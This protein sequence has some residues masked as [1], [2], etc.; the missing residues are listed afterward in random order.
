MALTPLQGW[1][2]PDAASAPAN[3]ASFA[4]LGSAA[5]KQSVMVFASAAARDAAI[6][7]A[8]RKKGMIAFLTDVAWWTGVKVDGGAWMPVAGVQSYR[9]DQVGS[10]ILTAAYTDVPSATVTLP[11]GQWQVRATGTIDVSTTGSRLYFMRVTDGVN[12]NFT[13][14]RPG[15]LNSTTYGGQYQFVA[16][17]RV[18][19][20]ASTTVRVQAYTDVVDGSQGLALV[21]ITATPV[22]Y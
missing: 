9:A 14:L 21:T 18:T 11:A 17:M 8:S 20:A 1:P 4:A 15:L 22:I 7:T 16:D 19:Y 12:E 10:F 3:D 13:R 6:A 2:V 5:E